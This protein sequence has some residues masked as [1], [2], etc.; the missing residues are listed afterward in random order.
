MNISHLTR[1]AVVVAGLLSCTGLL[2]SCGGPD[3]GPAKGKDDVASLE[4]GSASETKVTGPER[5]PSADDEKGRP[6]LRLDST[7][8][9]RDQYWGV[10]ATCLKEHGHKMILSRG[11]YSIDQTDDSPTA[12]AATRAC[13]GKLALQPPELDKDKNPHFADDWRAYIK[14]LN[15]NGLKVASFSDNSGWTY[16]SDQ[17]TLSED[18][19]NK[20]DKSCR[21]EAF[22]GRN[23]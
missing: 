1:Q 2:V 23:R 4:S 8:A 14:C 12:R 7:D 18:A 3:A 21:L 17:R 9:E 19:E 13:A 6:Q 16:T 11:P 15:K 5:A 10:Y 22:G 20:V